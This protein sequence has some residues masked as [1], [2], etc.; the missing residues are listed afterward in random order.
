MPQ[1]LLDDA[2]LSHG[3]DD[4]QGAL[5]THGAAFHIH[6]KHPLKGIVALAHGERNP[7]TRPGNPPGSLPAT[8]PHPGQPGAVPGGADSE[9]PSD[10]TWPLKFL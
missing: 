9:M 6:G 1:D 3:G 8:T 7:C 4:P 10:A 2:P 5:L